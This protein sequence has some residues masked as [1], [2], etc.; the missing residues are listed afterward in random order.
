MLDNGAEEL[1]SLCFSPGSQREDGA[2]GAARH[3]ERST[4]CKE[5]GGGGQPGEAE[6]PHHGG[7]LT[8]EKLQP[9][10][11]GH[12]GAPGQSGG[13][14]CQSDFSKQRPEGGRRSVPKA[15]GEGGG[16]AKHSNLQRQYRCVTQTQKTEPS[17][18][19]TTY[20]ID[21]DLT[22]PHSHSALHIQTPKLTYNLVS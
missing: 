17:N 4:A 10:R 3:S 22:T 20:L 14:E 9:A 2:S 8:A 16:D 5:G 6:G 1:T 19:W 15:D 11:E 12:G 18:K 21:L 7:R 13:Q